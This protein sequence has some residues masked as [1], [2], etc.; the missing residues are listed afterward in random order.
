LAQS[1]IARDVISVP[2]SLTI[3]TG[4]PRR[5]MIAS[6]SRARRR[7]PIDVST[8]SASASRV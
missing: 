6:S 7:P 8:T 4:L 5:A 2:L 3:V 1:R